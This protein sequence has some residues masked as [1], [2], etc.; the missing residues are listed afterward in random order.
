MMRLLTILASFAVSSIAAMIVLV[1]FGWIDSQSLSVDR[2][3]SIAPLFAGGALAGAWFSLPIAIPMIIF[4]E[5]SRYHSPWVFVL[6]GLA[7]GVGLIG[8]VSDYPLVEILAFPPYIVRDLIVIMLVA[9][10]ATLTYWLFAWKLFAPKP[11]APGDQAA[12]K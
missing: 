12:V 2:I 3:G 11:R 1:L 9:M 10:T 7:T 8:L 6:A 5:V 4:T